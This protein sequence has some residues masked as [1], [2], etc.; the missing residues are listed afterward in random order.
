MDAE[1]DRCSVRLRY[2]NGMPPDRAGTLAARGDR[3][4]GTEA[5]G[6]IPGAVQ[7]GQ[8]GC[9]GISLQRADGAEEVAEV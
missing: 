5:Q 6:V 7:D 8:R 3:D 1:R 4:I 9:R 2:S